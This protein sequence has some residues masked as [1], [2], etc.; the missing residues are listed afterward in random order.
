MSNQVSIF[1]RARRSKGGVSLAPSAMMGLLTLLTDITVQ[2]GYVSLV[3]KPWA[4]RP[5]A[6]TY[7]PAACRILIGAGDPGIIADRLGRRGTLRGAFG[8]PDL[9]AGADAADSSCHSA[10]WDLTG[11]C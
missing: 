1:T 11:M 2:S 3:A 8:S 5:H 9:H 10:A 4:C 7:D 6:G